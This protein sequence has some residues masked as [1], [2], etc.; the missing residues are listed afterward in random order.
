MVNDRIEDLSTTEPLGILEK[1]NE[2]IRA[3]NTDDV[4]NQ[5]PIELLTPDNASLPD[6][7]RVLNDIIRDINK[8]V[9]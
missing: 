7:V 6:V 2:I 3:V 5:V 4:D 8:E 9:R 1:I